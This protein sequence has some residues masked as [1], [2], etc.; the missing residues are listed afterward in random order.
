MNKKLPRTNNDKKKS[1]LVSR[2]RD[3][4]SGSSFN[5]LGLNV[6]IDGKKCSILNM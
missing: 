5:F 6:L 2:I 3:S 1:Q 4:F